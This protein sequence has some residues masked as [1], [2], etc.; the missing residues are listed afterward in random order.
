MLVKSVSLGVGPD[1]ATTHG[2]DTL[3]RWQSLW[4]SKTEANLKLYRAGEAGVAGD[5]T[6]LWN[7]ER[8]HG[9]IE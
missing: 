3:S 6:K 7:A 2:A 9:T 5:P 8:R 1:W 4:Y